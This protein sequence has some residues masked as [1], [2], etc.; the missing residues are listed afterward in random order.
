MHIGIDIDDVIFNW[1]ERAHVA[2]ERAGITN[3]VYPSKWNMHEDY[4]CTLEEWLA[5]LEVATLDGTLYVGEPEPGVLE[6]LAA[7]DEANHNIHIVTA[8][9]FFNH[10]DLIRQHT[11]EWLRDWDIPHQSLTFTKNKA[12][13]RLDVAIDD[14]WKNV[15]EM[16]AA[17]TITYL[18]NRPHNAEADYL[19]RVDDI[20]EFANIVLRSRA[21]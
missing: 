11:I 5:A 10:G 19:R 14:S 4:G 6:A 16:A 2:C 17:G 8:R 15:R 12:L 13:L 20:T 9:G 21:A 7:I 3:G 1:W 18:R